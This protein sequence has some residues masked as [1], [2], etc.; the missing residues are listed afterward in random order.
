VVDSWAYFAAEPGSRFMSK[1]ITIRHFALFREI[2]GRREEI[3]EISDE[4][5]AGDVLQQLVRE[6][7]QLEALTNSA[8]IMVNHTYSKAATPLSNGDE[9]AFIPPV[10]GGSGARLLR[11]TADELDPRETESAV[12]DPSCGAVLTFIGEV[13]DFARGETVSALDYE[14]YAEAAVLQ[15]EV[16]VEEIAEK[17]GVDRVAIIHR[18]GLLKPG[19]ASVIISVASPHRAEAFDACR[20]AI[21]RL[22]QL[23]PIWKK[24]HY[25][26]GAVWVG[27]E[28]DYQSEITGR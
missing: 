11:V 6:F 2:T 14:A 8:M 25:D 21:E 19:D 13:R 9:L 15:M 23:V 17:T 12:R 28:A 18:T 1:T 27:S 20:H 7:P 4:S 26:N 10:S 22:K 3:R 16:I 5:T 24:E